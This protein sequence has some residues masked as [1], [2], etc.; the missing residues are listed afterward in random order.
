MPSVAKKRVRGGP[1]LRAAGERARAPNGRP[2]EAE[3]KGQLPP[4]P[5]TFDWSR[6]EWWPAE[7]RRLVQLAETWA[8]PRPTTVRF[9]LW[10]VAAAAF[11]R[12]AFG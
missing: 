2:L 5:E 8:G 12:W 1:A 6:V 3:Q 10:M 11:F 7:R 4:K 9:L